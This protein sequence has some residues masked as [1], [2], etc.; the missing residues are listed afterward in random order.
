MG[1]V[2]PYQWVAWFG[3]V[4]LLTAA[5]LAALNIYPYYVWF[6][7]IS[8]GLWTIIGLL[9]RENSLIVMNAGLTLIYVLGLAFG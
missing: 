4:M 6:F 1:E 7:I 3:T 2:K 5:I 8:N 9:W